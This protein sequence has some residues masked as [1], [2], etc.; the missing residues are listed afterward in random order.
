MAIETMRLV[1]L[2]TQP[3]NV[4][5]MIDYILSVDHFH[6]ELASTVMNEG[7][8]G[9][10]FPN[11]KIY[12]S[13][14]NRCERIVSDLDLNLDDEFDRE[15]SIEEIENAITEAEMR[16]N[17]LHSHETSSALDS[18]DK[19]ALN[20]L[21]E[22]PMDHIEDSFIRLKFGRIPTASLSKIVLH[23]DKRFVF[24]VLHRNKHY[25]W[26]AY[27]SLSEDEVML[28]ELFDSLYFEPIA[29][30]I[31][32]EEI[33]NHECYELLDH[34]YGYVKKQKSKEEFLKYITLFGEEVVLT[35]FVAE[36]DIDDFRGLFTDRVVIRDFPANSEPGLLPPTKLKNGWF[37]RPFKLFIEMYG[38][39]QYDGF[40]P[41]LYF[42][43]T[44]C[45]LF[46]IM[47]GDVGQ[48]LVL[49]LGGAYLDKK[50][51]MEL[52]AVASRLG[53]SSVFFG[54]LFGSFF[55]NETILNPILKPVGL[56]IHVASPEF[57]MPLLI[58][59]VAL[60]SIL[61]LSSILI[62][63]IL[64][65]RAKK[66][67]EALFSQNGVAGFMFYGFVLANIAVM[68]S[69]AAIKLMNPITII[70]FIALPLASILL[71]EPLSN[72]IHKMSATPHEGWGGYITEGLF[73]LFEVVLGFVTNTMSFLRVGGFVLSHAGM[74]SVVIMLTEM[75][76]NA[77]I[78]AL[79]LGN[80]LVIG[81]EGLI[82]GIQTLRLEYY[83]MFS[84][85]YDGGGKK[86]NSVY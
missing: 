74:M 45:L 35:G 29:I 22:Y 70:L 47:F 32:T 42:A 14:L 85:Y 4:F 30:P 52:G 11:E 55:G 62:N 41:T 80:I 19:I 77:G 20:A 15:Y 71:K 1:R 10:P 39:P 13:F 8:A 25:G 23:A 78:V 21:K 83:E 7:N 84:R 81:L 68:F 17:T 46:G 16:Y 65:F 76:G 9:L 66:V 58:T 3:D 64:C 54:F 6:P 59:A 43:L 34:I 86:F 51:G 63:I 73:E 37:S 53:V 44:F 18:D 49:V 2:A 61:I 56:P 72:M 33:L 31:V 12:E 57:T 40:D 50:K 60:G 75:S 28:R 79:I 48:G 69:G 5:K 38:L 26:I 24:T 36:T 67:D 82:V 27:L